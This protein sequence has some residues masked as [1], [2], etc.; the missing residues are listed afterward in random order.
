MVV[1]VTDPVELVLRPD[2]STITPGK[3]VKK[4]WVA[5]DPIVWE[6][7][8][9]QML[10]AKRLNKWKLIIQITIFENAGSLFLFNNLLRFYWSKCLSF[11]YRRRHNA[12]SCFIKAWLKNSVFRFHLQIWICC[13]WITKAWS[14]FTFTSSSYFLF[15][16]SLDLCWALA[17]EVLLWDENTEL[18][19]SLFFWLWNLSLTY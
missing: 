2:E 6:G 5:G 17:W 12:T 3:L 10:I 4:D 13:S 15:L 11:L 8:E 16:L 14:S 9:E 1:V 19:E 18:T 7:R